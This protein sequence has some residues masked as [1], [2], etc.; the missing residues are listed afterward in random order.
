MLAMRLK[1]KLNIAQGLISGSRARHF[2]AR[3]GTKRGSGDRIFCWKNVSNTSLLG[4]DRST[5]GLHLEKRKRWWVRKAIN[6]LWSLRVWKSLLPRATKWTLTETIQFPRLIS[7]I[8]GSTV[9]RKSKT[10][11]FKE[12]Q[13]RTSFLLSIYAQFEA[14]AWFLK[15]RNK[16]RFLFSNRSTSEYVRYVFSVVP[17]AASILAFLVVIAFLPATMRCRKVGE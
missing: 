16:E 4:I 6:F 2:C 15:T 11:S 9:T 17:G 7:S 5:F 3:I 12:I 14:K 10:L 13:Q 8:A 1:K